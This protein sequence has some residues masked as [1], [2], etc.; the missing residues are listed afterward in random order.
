MHIRTI[1]WK[2]KDMNRH[3]SLFPFF[4]GCLL[5]L[6]SAPLLAEDH[7][8]R[9]EGQIHS[10]APITVTAER[11][12]Q[13]VKD[14]PRNV[15]I[16]NQEEIKKR[17]FLEVGE[18]LASMPGVD[19]RQ[20]SGS[21]GTKISIRGG[22]SGSVLILVDGRPINS[23]Q[24][25]GVDLNSIPIEVVKKVMVFKPPVPVWLGQG[26]AAGAVNI[27]TVSPT[28][29]RSKKNENKGRFKMR[30]GSYGT[31]NASCTYTVSRDQ[32]SIM[33]TAGGGHKDGKR[34]NSDRDSGNFSFNWSK[35]SQFQT[36]YDLNVRYYQTEH[37]SS[38]PTDNETTNARQKY[39]KGSLDF[40]TN[41]L[42]GDTGE[43][44]MKW[45]ADN[46]ELKD[47][48][49]DGRISTLEN[50][51]YGIKGE[52]IWSHEE[53]GALRLGGLL[54]KNEVE[55]DIS[56]DHH[57]E[58]ASLYL[59]HD[60]EIYDFTITLG[61]RGEHTSDFGYFPAGNIGLS[62]TVGQNT[63]LKTNAGYS[64]EIPSFNQLYQP[65]HGSIDQVRG[66]PDLSEE[67]IY[68]YDLSLEH[69]FS[70][71]TILSATLFRTDTRDMIIYLRD[72]NQI[73]HPE[74]ISR[75]YKQG[76]EIFLTSKWPGN[77]S[78]DLSY[79][80]QNTENKETNKDLPYSPRHNAKLTGKFV[81]PTG[82]KVEAIFKALSHQYSSPGTVQSKKLDSYCVVN[83]KTIH[84][85]LIKSL[86]SEIFVHINNLFDTNFESH[87]G[88][89]D[90]GFRFIAGMNLNF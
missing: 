14:H 4:T 5:F 16:M 76:I 42:I 78:L 44:T 57:R 33:L 71:K 70:K 55:H 31:A 63:L 87:A 24:Y 80:Y 27:V 8:S 46:G 90:D 52:S 86:P 85:I 10:L 17:N 49:D 77:I 21:M 50:Y 13:Y 66:N 79:I 69:S 35:K 68:S 6:L 82:T 73:Y 15:V 25:G 45:Y 32:G 34:P 51:K 74:N 12:P 19:V 67:N 11:I 38:G 36:R 53:K 72:D 64:V 40:H 41:G 88:Y 54:E 59:Q 89:P 61:L 62:Y 60:R 30:G 48:A 43:F 2:S 56:G 65:S 39:R 28:R 75:A 83:L 84:P 1:K 47:R 3:I 29:S 9:V 22:G 7:S 23:S 58:K 81:L 26:S 18:A 20:S 37:G